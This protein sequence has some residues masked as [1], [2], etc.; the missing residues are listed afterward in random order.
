M[1]HFTTIQTQIRDVAAL[2]DACTEL[3]L[4]L[5]R[6][7]EARGYAKQTRKGE[8]VIRLN[9]PYDIAANRAEGS[10]H[11]GLTTDW[12]DGHVEKEVGPE[13]GRLLQLYGVHKTIREAQKKRLRVTRRQESDGS[14][15][16][17]LAA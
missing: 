9:G 7:A 15:K 3:G 1:S 11:Y 17:T 10:D 4:E 14:I 16:L 8:L 12:W 2:E 13:Y 5:L 6:E